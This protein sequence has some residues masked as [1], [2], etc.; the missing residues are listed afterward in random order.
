[1]L[2]LLSIRKDFNLSYHAHVACFKPYKAYLSLKTWSG[3][4]KFLKPWGCLT[5]TSSIIR[6]F[7]NA[8]LTFI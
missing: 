6:P 1:M 2:K 7:E 8:L 4:W 5:Y 3:K